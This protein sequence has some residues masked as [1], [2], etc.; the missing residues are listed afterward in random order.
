MC[1]EIT[2]GEQASG[3]GSKT[4]ARQIPGTAFAASHAQAGSLA[5]A[6]ASARQVCSL[7]A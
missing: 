3:K 2:V 1:V 5:A 6:M 4:M 7:M